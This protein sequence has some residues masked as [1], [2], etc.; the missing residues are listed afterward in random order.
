[1]TGDTPF[2][3]SYIVGQVL[4]NVELDLT[5][6]PTV[7]FSEPVWTPAREEQSRDRLHRKEKT[8]DFRSMIL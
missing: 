7:E 8:L 3:W 4:R 6:P 1:M 2:G 5:L